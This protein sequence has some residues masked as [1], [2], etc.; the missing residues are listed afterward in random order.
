MARLGY[1]DMR[2]AVKEIMDG[3]GDALVITSVGTISREVFAYKDRPENMYIMGAM[4]CALGV[5]IGLAL[6]TSRRVVVIVGDGDV[7]MSLGT[8]VL[9]N[10]LERKKGLRN[11]KLYIIDNQ[12]YAATGGQKTCSGGMNFGLIASCE[13]V[14]VRSEKTSAPRIPLEPTEI[15]RR[16]HAAVKG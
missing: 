8:L 6:N 14:H 16:F 13:V 11:I 9:L 4:G 1:N 7:L 3:V 12:S 15:M 10:W 2:G 5:G